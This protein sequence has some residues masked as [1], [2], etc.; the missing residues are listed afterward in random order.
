MGCEGRKCGGRD[1][2]LLRA[3]GFAVLDCVRV[4]GVGA[5]LATDRL[6]DCVKI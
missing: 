2:L 3:W 4:M 5:Q 6:G 1:V